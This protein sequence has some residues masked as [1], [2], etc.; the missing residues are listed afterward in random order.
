MADVVAH[1]VGRVGVEVRRS[2]GVGRLGEVAGM[3]A[4]ARGILERR[5]VDVGAQD[6]EPRE[7]RQLAGARGVQVKEHG[8]RIR[9]L[10]RRAARAPH[11]QPRVG[12][13]PQGRDHDPLQHLVHLAVAEEARDVDRE[14]IHEPVVLACIGVEHMN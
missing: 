10:A 13:R 8:Q 2:H 14:R 4:P 3:E 7:P 5:A 12:P 6:V 1:R 11:A 9:L